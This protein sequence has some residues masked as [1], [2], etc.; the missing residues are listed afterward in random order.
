MN[1]WKLKREREGNCWV[2]IKWTQFSQHVQPTQ[3]LKFTFKSQRFSLELLPL[4]VKLSAILS[5]SQIYVALSVVR[6]TAII[7]KVKRYVK[8]IDNDKNRRNDSYV[9]GIC[10]GKSCTTA[11]REIFFLLIV[12]QKKKIFISRHSHCEWDWR[13][14]CV[15]YMRRGK[16]S[17]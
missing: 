1:E 2:F 11:T 10:C 7:W 9:C 5:R 4:W 16:E 14:C 13:L 6:L 8:F 12:T 15:L 3:K 17:V